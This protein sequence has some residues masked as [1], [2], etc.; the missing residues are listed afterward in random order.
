MS[1]LS[2]IA[3]TR[4][5]VIAAVAICFFV[6]AVLV[7]LI[8]RLA[9]GRRLRMS[10]ARGRQ[11]RLGIVDAF[12][13]DRQRQLVIVR[14]DNTEH[15]VMIGGPNDVLIESQIVRAEARETR[16]R[17]K[18]TRDKDVRDKEIRD[19]EFKEPPQVSQTPPTKPAPP[20]PKLPPLPS[21]PPLAPEP[22]QPV[23]Q[24]VA[25]PVRLQPVSRTPMPPAATPR[26]AQPRPDIKPLPELSAKVEPEWPPVSAVP[27]P[28]AS[29]PAVSPAAPANAPS[30]LRWPA[31]PAGTGPAVQPKPSGPAAVPPPAHSAPTASV[32]VPEP[33][34]M[35]SLEEEMAKLLGR[36]PNKP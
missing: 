17:E 21:M 7:L 28:P 16:G 14:R 24:E 12:D 27:I 30:F 10:G 6:A 18:D 32:E 33:D 31:R 4:P 5:L 9:F 25:P 29:K 15:L 19:R 8:F 23:A 34:P 36:S 3:E 22:L 26:R 35:E 1:A 2:S 11:L 20:E 13:L